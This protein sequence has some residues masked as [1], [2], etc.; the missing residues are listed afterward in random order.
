MN[1]YDNDTIPSY[2]PSDTTDWN[3]VDGVKPPQVNAG[4]YPT[5]LGRKVRTVG[6]K[7]ATKVTANTINKL[8]WKL[9]FVEPLSPSGWHPTSYGETQN[10]VS[11]CKVVKGRHQVVYT[12]NFVNTYVCPMFGMSQLKLPTGHPSQPE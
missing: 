7:D 9:G 4:W 1:N 8:A 6:T 10:M 3:D 11:Q 12:L 2:T 5:E